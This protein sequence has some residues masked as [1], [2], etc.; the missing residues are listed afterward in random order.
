[1]ALRRRAEGFMFQT[2]YRNKKWDGYDKFLLPYDRESDPDTGLPTN[3]W[4]FGVGLWQVVINTLREQEIP[5]EI[6]NLDKLVDFTV[7]QVK[8]NS[9]VEFLLEGIL[10]QD[11]EQISPRDYQFESAF[12]ALKYKY[13]TQEL[14][15][16]AG[17]TIIFYTYISFLQFKQKINRKGKKAL[18]VVPKVGLVDQT[19]D[20]FKTEYNNGRLAQ[21]NIMRVGGKSKWDDEDF[22]KADLVISTY[23]SLA[24][25]DPE[26]FKEFNV[27]CIDEC[28]TAKGSTITDIIKASP[29]AEY[30]FGLSGTVLSESKFSHT[31][32]IQEF[33]GPLRMIVSSAFLQT[34]K[35]SPNVKIRAVDLVHPINPTTKW[36]DDQKLLFKEHG[37]PPEY[38]DA[39]AF[40]AAMFEAEKQYLY[41]SDR[42]LDVIS[43]LVRKLPGN[44]LILFNNIKD[45]YGKRVQ[46]KLSEWNDKVYYV[47]GSIQNTDRQTFMRDMEANEGVIIV[48]SYGTFSTG[49]NIKRLHNIVCVESTK[50]EIT[51][52]QSIGRLMRMFAEKFEVNVYD[53]IDVFEGTVK[54]NYMVIHSKVRQS[55]YDTQKFVVTRHKVRL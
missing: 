16:S 22:E 33:I 23:Q 54:E 52:R 51:L 40:G 29:N 42:R 37:L 14:A 55:I 36:L 18:I 5:Y 32:K 4:R 47:D 11:G 19:Y 34:E 50:S 45:Q 10:D 6:E 1:M 49:L 3:K 31:F 9:F 20:A 13:C 17:K 38:S 35:F 43:N 41:S 2:R 46:E 48:A 7:D 39:K 8:L 27:V 44:T 28:H 53:L 30:K 12:R 24:N 26:A 25:I 21:L 15:T